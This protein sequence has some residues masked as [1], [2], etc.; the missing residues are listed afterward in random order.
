M[1]KINTPI[2]LTVQTLEDLKR[3]GFQYVL[4]KGYTLDR[5]LDYIQM[6]HFTLVPVRELPV[7]PTE[8]E[9]FEPIDSEILKEWASSPDNG[10]TAYIEK[11]TE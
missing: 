7:N 11:T 9:I 6:N 2:K 10:L 3:K 1:P 8:K 5:R 4:I